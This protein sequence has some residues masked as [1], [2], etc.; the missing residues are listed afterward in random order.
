MYTLGSVMNF[1]GLVKI[2]C[3]KRMNFKT[4]LSGVSGNLQVRMQMYYLWLCKTQPF[5]AMP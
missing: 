1:K 2:A 3:Q 5:E 4:K